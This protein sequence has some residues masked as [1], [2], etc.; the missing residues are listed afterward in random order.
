MEEAA[1]AQL[2]QHIGRNLGPFL[3]GWVSLP[4]QRSLMQPDRRWI[5][6]AV[7]F[8]VMLHQLVLWFANFQTERLY[9]KI[10][11]VRR[12]PC[13]PGSSGGGQPLSLAMDGA[14]LGHYHGVRAVL[15]VDGLCQRLWPV[16]PVYQHEK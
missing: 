8:G 7:L 5:V 1:K 15:R 9:I 2:S 16:C 11:V 13:R 10:T 3:L 6:D 12:S 4:T 14:P